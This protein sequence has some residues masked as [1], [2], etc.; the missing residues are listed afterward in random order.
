MICDKCGLYRPECG[1]FPEKCQER[2]DREE[3]K[4]ECRKCNYR[5]D[6]WRCWYTMRPITFWT[7]LVVHLF[8]CGNYSPWWIHTTKEPED[9]R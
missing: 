9:W 5:I 8:G 3:K 6:G 7:K 1:C 4:A 2:E